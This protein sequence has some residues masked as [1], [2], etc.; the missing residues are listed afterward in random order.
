ML[1]VFSL[2]LLPFL[3]PDLSCRDIMSPPRWKGR[4]GRLVVMRVGRSRK[5]TYSRRH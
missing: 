1:A 4:G 3:A 5:N 2:P